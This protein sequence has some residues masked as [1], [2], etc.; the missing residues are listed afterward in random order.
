MPE[1]YPLDRQREP[2]DGESLPGDDHHH[3]NYPDHHINI[4]PYHVHKYVHH[5]HGPDNDDILIHDHDGPDQ[6]NHY[7]LH[8]KTTADHLY[9]A[10]GHDHDDPD[11][12]QNRSGCPAG[13]GWCVGSGTDSAWQCN[14]CWA[15][16]Q[17]ELT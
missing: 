8:D 15:K 3:H 6:H 14:A 5:H 11:T 7:V 16:T 13:A 2:V 4:D 1:R 17:A 9:G 10:A 12:T